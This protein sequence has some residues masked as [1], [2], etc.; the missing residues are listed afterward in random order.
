MATTAAGGFIGWFFG[1]G[2]TPA[3]VTSMSIGL[4]IG[5]IKLWD[6]WRRARFIRRERDTIR[7]EL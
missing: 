2:A 7:G 4:L 5:L 1:P 3:V 6:A